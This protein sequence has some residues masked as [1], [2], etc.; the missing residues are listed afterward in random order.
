MSQDSS[1]GSK[2]GQS[3]RDKAAWIGAGGLVTA[4][5]IAGIFALAAR[6][7][8]SATPTASNP[9]DS[10]SS[11][12]PTAKPTPTA[13]APIASIDLTPRSLVPECAAISGHVSTGIVS[14]KQFWLF[15][16]I[17]K[18]H[19][20]RPSNIFYF[21]R[22]LHPDS[23]GVWSA[24]IQLGER[25]EDGSLYWLDVVSSD[26]SLTGPVSVKGLEEGAL[27][28]LPHNFND[29]PLVNI[30]VVRGASNSSARDKC[31]TYIAIS[32]H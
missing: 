11:N 21:L 15:T 32:G 29:R 6:G 24:D 10:V 22:Q 14:G 27:T 19:S 31:R 12:A 5:I 17:P 26:P 2:D 3:S 16:K 18:P 25:G 13:T 23:Q 28:G 7:G 8:G 20:N 9:R 4:A 1:E 30:E